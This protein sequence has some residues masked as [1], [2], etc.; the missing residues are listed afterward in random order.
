MF[1]KKKHVSVVTF[2]AEKEFA[3]RFYGR[4]MQKIIKWVVEVW[5]TSERG[6]VMFWQWLW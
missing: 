5:T 4:G 1:K 6:L 3:I 2:S